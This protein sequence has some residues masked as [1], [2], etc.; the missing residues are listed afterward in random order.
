MVEIKKRIKKEYIMIYILLFFAVSSITLL[1]YMTIKYFNTNHSK[2]ANTKITENTINAKNLDVLEEINEA[3][4][5]YKK[6]KNNL[7]ICNNLPST[8]REGC[9]AHYFTNLAY[10]K[11]DPST[12]I[13]I[14]SYLPNTTYDVG[15][16][17]YLSMT[18]TENYCNVLKNNKKRYIC[19]KIINIYNNE[20]KKE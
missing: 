10:S 17:I 19:E 11:R 9:I 5:V 7:K 2:E 6:A 8:Y 20:S 4:E 14:S 13:N 3:V 12:C 1:S 16:I 15:C 18:Y